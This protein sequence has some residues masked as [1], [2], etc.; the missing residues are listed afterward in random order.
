MD[1]GLEALVGFVASHGD[2]FE[3]LEFTEEILDQMAPFI[4]LP[5]YVQRL[6]TAWVL[7][8]H[9]LR[10]ALVHVLD[11]PVRI[12]GLV[13]DQAAEFD[14]L[15][16]RGDA[17]GIEA[18][19][20]QQNKAHQIAQS[21]R[22]GQDFGCPTAFRLAYGLALSPPFAPWPWRWTLTMVPSIIANSMSG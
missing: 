13:G 12:K 8:D 18:L 22:Q 17:D 20:R 21:V 14:I 7:R 15:D 6:D 11:D 16:K 2:A 3:L 9:D 19:S 4:D 10:P 5:I 1:H